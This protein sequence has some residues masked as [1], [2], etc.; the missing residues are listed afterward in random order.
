MEE[1]KLRDEL[2][3]LDAALKRVK[4][5][6]VKSI[7]REPAEAR[8]ATV[9]EHMAGGMDVLYVCT[10]I[11][12]K[13]A[14][15]QMTHPWHIHTY[16]GVR[17]VPLINEKQV[18]ESRPDPKPGHPYLNSAR[19]AVPAIPPK[20]QKGML[21][22]I[23]QLLLDVNLPARPMPTKCVCDLYD[24]LRRDMVELF[25]LQKMVKQKESQVEALRSGA[26]PNAGQY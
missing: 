15:K 18:Q 19:L 1:L 11:T 17:L 24:D 20:L 16:T 26:D 6:P 8:D 5:H 22:K 2:K 25:T 9:Q 21:Q 13:E 7:V 3:T 12:T 10:Y 14:R 23:K 4:K